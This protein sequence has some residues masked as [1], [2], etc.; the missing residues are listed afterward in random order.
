[1]PDGTNPAMPDTTHEP[2]V[3]LPTDSPAARRFRSRYGPWAVVTGATSGIGRA[4]ATHLAGLGLNLVLVARRHGEL[5][6]LAQTLR[7]PHPTGPGIEVKVVP[8]DLSEP[9]GRGVHL[10]EEACTELDV[11]LLVAAACFGTAGTFVDATLD[12]ELEM[13]ALNGEA[14]LRST[15]HFGRRF[16]ER[17]KGGIVLFGSIV[18]F[19]GTPNTAHYAAT[20]AY[21]QTLA[22][23]L[24]L[25]LALR[26]VDV[27]SSAPGPV[28]SGFAERA[29]MI[30]GAATD[31]ETVV[32]VTF[33]ALGRRPTTYP[34]LL[35]RVLTG[36]LAPLP[37]RMRSLIMGRVLGGMVRAPAQGG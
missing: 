37:R 4:A 11:G 35:T 12:R 19:Q 3:G 16:A 29:G 1:M 2:A 7:Q 31:P 23:G 13:L 10:L 30:M 5:E 17:G 32:R 34:G 8:A 28:H 25:E 9:G 21:I 26:G 14:V 33:R 6:S 24:Y 27:I 20:K 22:E 18:G 36:S 15:H